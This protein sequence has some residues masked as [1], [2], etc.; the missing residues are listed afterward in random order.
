M[1]LE[2][3]KLDSMKSFLLRLKHDG[4]LPK[5]KKDVANL[6]KS[7]AGGELERVVFAEWVWDQNAIAPDHGAWI[8]SRCNCPNENIHAMK[9]G[10]PFAWEGS[11]YCPYC[12]ARFLKTEKGGDKK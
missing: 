1:D 8:C 9:W 5:E 4:L 3:L 12:G 7:Y 2:K 11:S 10:D 6:V